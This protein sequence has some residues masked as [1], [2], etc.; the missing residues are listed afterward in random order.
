VDR[1]HEE[2]AAGNEE[3]PRLGDDGAG[4]EHVLEE[5]PH[6]DDV[7]RGRGER[8][9]EKIALPYVEPE[10]VPSVRGVTRRELHT[11]DGPSSRASEIEEDTRRAADIQQPA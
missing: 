4:I 2:E 9:R 10:L 3:P 8:R 5:V 11:A 6:R 7:K 1:E